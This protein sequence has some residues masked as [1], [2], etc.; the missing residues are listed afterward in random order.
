MATDVVDENP[1]LH[2]SLVEQLEPIFA[3]TT[4]RNPVHWSQLHKTFV[5]GG[6][7][8][9]AQLVAAVNE[10]LLPRGSVFGTDNKFWLF[11]RPIT[12]AP[13]CATA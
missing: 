12:K 6:K 8:D 3:E 1:K 13:I 4:E 10:H 5:E 9:N 2:R 11:L 7:C